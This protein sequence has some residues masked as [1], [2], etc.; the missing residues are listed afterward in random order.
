MKIKTKIILS[1]ILMIA[2]PILCAGLIGFIGVKQIDSKY[3]YSLEK[4]FEDENA[5]VSAQSTI[6]EY[7]EELWDTNWK[8]MEEE[9]IGHQGEDEES[10]IKWSELEIQKNELNQSNEM[11]NLG[12]ELETMG[13]HFSVFMNGDCQ[14]S[15]LTTADS[16]IIQQIAGNSITHVRSMVVGE[17]RA[18][19]I[20]NSFEKEESDCVI[21]AVNNGNIAW[22]E[23]EISYLKQHLL[24]FIVCFL[25]IVVAVIFATNAILS[26]YILKL[27]LPPLQLLSSGTK[28]IREGDLDTPIVYL[29]NDEIGEVCE[30]FEEMRGYLKE[31]ALERVRYET[32]RRELMSGIS[33]DLRTPLTSIKGYLEGLAT[34]IAKNMDMQ[35][36]YFRA[37]EVRTNDLERLVDNLSVYTR[38]ENHDIKY[39]KQRFDLKD[40]LSRYIYDRNLELNNNCIRISVVAKDQNYLVCLD[41]IELIRVFDNLFSNTFKY[42]K[43]S[44]SNVNISLEN[45]NQR[46]VCSYEDDAGGV[47]E[48][49]LHRIFDSFYRVDES[50]NNAGDG[51]GLGLAI[52]KDIITGQDGRIWAENGNS[53]LKIMIEVAEVESKNESFD[54]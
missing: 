36:R 9:E 13:Y 47:P 50:R 26:G 8:Q 41:Q 10:N 42:R 11:Y 15:N 16:E 34:G 46:I 22:N 23:N 39:E 7:Q 5:V 49:S 32:Y 28:R 18:S 44:V 21:I 31:S 51:S 27:I 2:I 30:D 24:Q 53:G 4:M 54:N 29:N 37:I 1:N 19:V 45:V 17:G 25:I 12:K 38:L 40:F 52:V 14:Y 3:L 20:K 48:E 6:Y 43:K 35:K 33:H